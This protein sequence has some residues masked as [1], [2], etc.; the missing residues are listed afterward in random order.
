MKIMDYTTERK[1][2]VALSVT[3]HPVV[4]LLLSL[5]IRANSECGERIADLDIEDTFFDDMFANLSPKT[6]AILEEMPSGETWISLLSL[7]PLSG[8]GGSVQ[9]FIDFLSNHDAVDLRSRMIW[10][11]QEVEGD[12]ATLAADAAAGRPGAVD[13][14]LDLES[15]SNPKTKPW[16]ETLRYILGLEPNESRDLL[17]DVLAEVQSSGFHEYE[18]EFSGYLE[19]DF[20][21]KKSMGRRLS[22]ERLVE[23]ATNGISISD[24]RLATPVILMPTM[25][26]RPWVVLA[27]SPDLFIMAYPVSDRTLASD[28]EAPPLW[29]VKLHKALGDERRLKI[30]RK[31]AQGDASLVELSTEVD[32]AKSTLHHHMMLLRAAGLIKVHV[33]QD[34]L[35]SLRDETLPE[36]AT[37]LNHYIHRTTEPREEQT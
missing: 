28:P 26:A 24:K 19:T 21:A 7:V 9:D 5:W 10:L 15:F 35:Y 6:K 16:R 1:Q 37:Y 3:Y 4:D 12:K 18:K 11:Y 34:K 27:E 36:A 14:L 8:E 23:I 29:L 33:G 25:V 30:L 20:K 31:L 22:A 2:E 13:A 17:V 32:I